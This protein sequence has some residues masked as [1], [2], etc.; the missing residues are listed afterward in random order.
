M[1]KRGQRPIEVTYGREEGPFFHKTVNIYL[2]LIAPKKKKNSPVYKAPAN[3]DPKKG[4]ETL[5]N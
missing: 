5:P 4:S 2:H 1:I 3:A